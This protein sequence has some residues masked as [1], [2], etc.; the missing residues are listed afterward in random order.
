MT[1]AM[2]WGEFAQA[3][4]ELAQLGEEPF[5]RTGAILLGT[6]RRDGTPRISPV[7]HLILDRELFLGMMWQSRKALDLLRDPRCLIHSM[8]IDKNDSAGEFKLRGRAVDVRDRDVQ[9]RYCQALQE[10]TGWRPEGPFH[11][12]AVDIETATHIKYLENGDQ[13]VMEWHPG[14]APTERRRR[15]TGSGVVDDP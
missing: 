13:L 1:G 5:E 14:S 12:F 11:L 2:N 15:W 4:P 6:S 8:V 3:A 9:E 7:E 10:K